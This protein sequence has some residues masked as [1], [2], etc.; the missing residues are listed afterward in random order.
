MEGL[1]GTDMGGRSVV[2]RVECFPFRF[3]TFPVVFYDDFCFAFLVI[4]F[5]TMHG[6]AVGTAS[7]GCPGF[8]KECLWELGKY[9]DDEVVKE[10]RY[11]KESTLRGWLGVNGAMLA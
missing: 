5:H 4:N 3:C 9:N 11:G 7:E 2:W 6:H 1:N 8:G 10:G